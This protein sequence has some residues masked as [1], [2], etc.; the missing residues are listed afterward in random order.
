MITIT[1]N[2]Y[3]KL[4]ESVTKEENH[5]TLD[6]FHFRKLEDPV[7]RVETCDGRRCHR[8]EITLGTEEEIQLAQVL[9]GKIFKTPKLKAK[10]H[11]SLSSDDA[12]KVEYHIFKGETLQRVEVAWEL[13]GKFPDTD[14]FFLKKSGPYRYLRVNTSLLPQKS[15]IVLRIPAENIFNPIDY[16]IDH[17]EDGEK[18]TGYGVFMPTK[19][20]NIQRE[21]DVQDLIDS[22]RKQLEEKNELTRTSEKA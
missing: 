13:D 15:I 21:D 9:D 16:T 3:K 14:M 10:E 2:Q 7:L 6:G 19:M 11:L 4:M 1:N 5:Y 18:G 20:D 8:V 22:L 12:G 17:T